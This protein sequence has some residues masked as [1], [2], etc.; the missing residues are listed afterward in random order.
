MDFSALIISKLLQLVNFATEIRIKKK[1]ARRAERQTAW[2]GEKTRHQY[3]KTTIRKY[4]N[5]DSMKNLNRARRTSWNHLKLSS[6]Q[7]YIKIGDKPYAYAVHNII[8]LK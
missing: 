6:R 3:V 7:K 5:S 1:S 4:F 2:G 8:Q